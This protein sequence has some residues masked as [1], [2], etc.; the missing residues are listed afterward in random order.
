MGMGQA[1]D[2]LKPVRRVMTKEKRK[3]LITD[4]KSDVDWAKIQEKG[5]TYKVLISDHHLAPSA[6]SRCDL[7]ADAA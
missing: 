6:L 2:E 1:R 5:F 4:D 3:V 7:R